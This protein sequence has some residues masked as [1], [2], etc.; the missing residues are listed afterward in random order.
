MHD[1]PLMYFADTRLGARGPECGEGQR[2]GTAAGQ[3]RSMRN[4][5]CGLLETVR[6][7]RAQTVATVRDL[8][9]KWTPP[10]RCQHVALTAARQPAEYVVDPWAFV[11]IARV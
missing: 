6:C 4:P 7:G 2:N 8:N 1:E 3:R 10:P 11:A 5:S 9:I